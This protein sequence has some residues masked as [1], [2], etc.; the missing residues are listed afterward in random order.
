ML[1]IV[2]CI[3]FLCRIGDFTLLRAVVTQAQDLFVNNLTSTSNTLSSRKEF[4]G[5]K[6]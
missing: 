4:Q 6:N 5:C 3:A 1:F 2:Y